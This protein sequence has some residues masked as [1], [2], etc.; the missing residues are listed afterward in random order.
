MVGIKTT[1]SDTA[2][3]N[4]SKEST[5]DNCTHTKHIRFWSKVEIAESA[6]ARVQHYRNLQDVDT[7]SF[8][9]KLIGYRQI[10][11]K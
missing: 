10:A 9:N 5:R 6:H 1:Y 8:V 3:N 7:A 4:D 2:M 11:N